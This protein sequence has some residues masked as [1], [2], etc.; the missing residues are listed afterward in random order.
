MGRRH[1]RKAKVYNG[2]AK[3]EGRPAK[4][5]LK[6][7]LIHYFHIDI[8]EIRPEEANLHWAAAGRRRLS[9]CSSTASPS[10]NVTAAGA[11]SLVGAQYPA[12]S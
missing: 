2:S 1:W 9:C 7:Y 6:P 3:T 4:K 8:A 12:R 10:A 5:L 11:R